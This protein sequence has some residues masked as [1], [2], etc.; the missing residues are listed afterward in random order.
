[1][2]VVRKPSIY[3]ETAAERVEPEEPLSISLF[4]SRV[5]CLSLSD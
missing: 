1:M 4:P 5:V 3:A 2:D